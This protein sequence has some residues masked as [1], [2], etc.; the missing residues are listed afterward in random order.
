VETMGGHMMKVNKVFSLDVEVAEKLQLE[1]NASKIINHLL[2]K[3]FDSGQNLEE[4]ELK[5]RIME[6]EKDLIEKKNHINSM[7]LRIKRIEERDKSIKK[8]FKKIPSSILE[9]FKRWPNM[10]ID[11]LRT[12]FEGGYDLEFEDLTW[13]D[14]LRAYKEIVEK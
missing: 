6:L 2:T 13:E 5:S 12:R 9:D 11:I 4:E 8:I 14:L 3:F 7:K 10:T 1:K